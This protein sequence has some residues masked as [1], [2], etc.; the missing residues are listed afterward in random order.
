MAIRT[1]TMTK[2]EMEFKYGSLERGQ[3]GCCECVTP[4]KVNKAHLKTKKKLRD[5]YGCVVADGTD[6]L[7][8][9]KLSCKGTNFDAFGP[10]MN[11]YYLIDFRKQ[12]LLKDEWMDECKFLMTLL[13][14]NVDS[15]KDF[16]QLGYKQI[17]LNL[18]A[19]RYG[20]VYTNIS[21]VD[22][23]SIIQQEL[24]RQGICF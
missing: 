20:K 15:V 3:M 4:V 18:I 24:S 11:Y 7:V 14:I 23:G 9:K 16:S 17:I 2:E 5:E 8:L 21:T 10:L 6:K 12:N 22:L 1:G 13:E 19:D